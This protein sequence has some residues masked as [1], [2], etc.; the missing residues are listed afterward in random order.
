MA[1]LGMSA[2]PRIVEWSSS[3]KSQPLTPPLPFAF[4]LLL[5]LLG[6]F[7]VLTVESTCHQDPKRSKHEGDRRKPTN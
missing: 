7:A 2:F 3:V 1:D 6:P 4:Q 5:A